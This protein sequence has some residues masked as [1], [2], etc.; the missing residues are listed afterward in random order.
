MAPTAAEALESRQQSE[1]VA[2]I[3]ETLPETRRQ[4]FLLRQHG[5]LSFREIAEQLDQPLGT[6]LSHMHRAV[7]ELKRGVANHVS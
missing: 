1:R 5:D 3:L 6:V 2:A 7:Q 4:V